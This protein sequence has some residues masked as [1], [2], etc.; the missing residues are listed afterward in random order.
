MLN[1]FGMYIGN[2]FIYQHQFLQLLAFLTWI[3]QTLKGLRF[4][5]ITDPMAL[6]CDKV[7]FDLVNLDQI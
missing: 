4:G 6:V 1:Q 2:E 3:L 7:L 5:S